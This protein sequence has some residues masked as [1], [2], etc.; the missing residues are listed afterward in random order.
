[1]STALAPIAPQLGKLVLMLS[2]NHDGEV[3]AAARA[4]DRVLKSSR[5]D[6]HDLAQAI[7]PPADHCDWHDLLAFCASH[8]IRLNSRERDFLQSIAR[9]R[10]DLTERQRNWLEYIAAKLRGGL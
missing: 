5:M 10:S 6:W 9:R 1:M 8:M 7:C 3:I 2:S 4:I